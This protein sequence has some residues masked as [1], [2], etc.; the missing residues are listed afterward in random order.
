MLNFLV[1]GEAMP[2]GNALPAAADGGAFPR[3]AGIN[4]LIILMTAFGATHNATANCGSLI[5]T[6]LGIVASSCK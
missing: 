4:H 2:A 5:C 3:G 6:T 1:S